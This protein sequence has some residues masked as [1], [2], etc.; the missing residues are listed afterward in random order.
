IACT[1]DGHVEAFRPRSDGRRSL[2]S[3]RIG[4]V[5][6]GPALDRSGRTVFVPSA[7]HHLYALRADDGR[8]RWRLRVPEPVLSSPLVATV[9]DD[10][11]VFF[12]A[13]TR[14]YA[15]GARDGR[16][17]WS[18][19]LHGFFAGRVAC[20]GTRIYAGGG[21]GNAYA[22]DA[23]T[24]DELWSFSTN[25]RETAYSRLIY[26]PWDDVV[27]TLPRDRVLVSTVTEAFALD[28]TTGE[29]AWAVPG[30]HIYAP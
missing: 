15:V 23:A 27:E 10:E 11:R 6:R 2:W 29:Q 18:S 28:R 8:Q 26:G 9:G 5:F 3:V 14:L 25:S 12:T 24:G 1:T 13:G 19:D 22:F 20:D 4:P 30:S 21:D 17:R 16:P 7:D